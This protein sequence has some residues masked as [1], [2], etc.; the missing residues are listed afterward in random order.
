MHEEDG[1]LEKIRVRDVINTFFYAMDEMDQDLLSSILHEEFKIELNLIPPIRITGRS[2]WI[3]T[4]GRLRQ[5]MSASNHSVSNCHINIK[6]ESASSMSN[7]VAYVRQTSEGSDVTRVRCIRYED[8][9]VRLKG[10]WLM[11]ER[12]HLPVWQFEATT[13]P[14]AL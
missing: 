10:R 14:L 1:I 5:T 2:E 7:V 9:F 4:F 8:S 13:A 3:S 11:T 12:R 6:G